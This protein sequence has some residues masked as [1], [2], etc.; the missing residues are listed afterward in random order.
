MQGGYVY[1]SVDHKRR[2]HPLFRATL[3]RG[4]QIAHLIFLYSLL[5]D[6]HDIEVYSVSVCD[7]RISCS[8]RNIEKYSRADLVTATRPERTNWRM[9]YF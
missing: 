3:S 1:K 8:W 2:C 4:K 7:L 5:F 6:A 9:S